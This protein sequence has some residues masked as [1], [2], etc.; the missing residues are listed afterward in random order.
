MSCIPFESDCKDAST[1]RGPG[2]ARSIRSI[3]AESLVDPATCDV[4]VNQSSLDIIANVFFEGFCV[5]ARV[6][7]ELNR[8]DALDVRAYYEYGIVNVTV[9]DGRMCSFVTQ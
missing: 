1:V 9:K 8:E 3:C 2:C 4:D 5:S 6:A 7:D